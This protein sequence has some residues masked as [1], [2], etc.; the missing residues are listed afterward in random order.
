MRELPLGITDF[1]LIRQRGLYYADK[2]ELL[3][4]LVRYNGKHFLSRPHQFGKT[5]LVSA[6][7]YI[8]QGR[9]DLFQG[10]WIDNSDYNWTPYPV[11][12]LDM[13]LFISDNMIDLNSNL[14]NYLIT[15]A[16]YEKID[17][18]D[19]TSAKN[20][21]YTF[22]VGLYI[23][24]GQKVAILI[25]DY[26][27]PVTN[28]TCDPDKAEM[29]SKALSN[30]YG[31]LKTNDVKIGHIFLTGVS[32]STETS[33]LSDLNSLYNI[34]RHDKF[35]TICGLTEADIDD[36]LIDYR[37]Q[38]LKSLIERKTINPESDVDDLRRLIRERYES[39]SC[40]RKT[41]VYNP[42]S[43]LNFFNNQK[44]SASGTIL[45]PQNF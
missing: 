43:I 15:L 18:I 11:I 2:T 21:L 29:I 45:D 27:A 19:I 12:K 31:I 7:M 44:S 8:L 33:V 4:E 22:I 3:Y 6:L 10:L 23:K 17:L 34:T 13:N 9:R 37:D 5:L 32:K 24:Y 25:D 40:D 30:F 14:I 28:L 41:V 39:Y 35:A 36:L 20:I 38:T 16:N 42:W 1:A 26:D